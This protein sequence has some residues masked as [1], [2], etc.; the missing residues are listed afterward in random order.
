LADASGPGRD[1]PLADA[2]GLGTGHLPGVL[3]GPGTDHRASS[4]RGTDHLDQ[5]HR[6]GHR[7]TKLHWQTTPDL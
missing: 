4:D 2:S 1:H 6:N 5:S 3:W 7:Q